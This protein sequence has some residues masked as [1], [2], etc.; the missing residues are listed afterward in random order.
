M[1]DKIKAVNNEMV[2]PII[3][4]PIEFVSERFERSPEERFAW[5]M[6][7]L[8]EDCKRKGRPIPESFTIYRKDIFPIA[9]ET[10]QTDIPEV[11]QALLPISPACLPNTLENSVT[12]TQ[13][14]SERS[15]PQD[16]MQIF[17]PAPVDAASN[18]LMTSNLPVAPLSNRERLSAIQVA[19]LFMRRVSL[20]VI[21]VSIYVFNGHF[22][23]KMNEVQMNR[24]V[25][26]ICCSETDAVG[27]PNFVRQV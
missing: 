21:G 4:D 24:K 10:A 1:K 22:F 6:K 5:S 23:Q 17:K 25:R 14:S 8:I 20:K 27:S 19:R 7:P 13:G 18:E 11:K 15:V 26:Q 16:V 2:H 12:G 9:A 3:I